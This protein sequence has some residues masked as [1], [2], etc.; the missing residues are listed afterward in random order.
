MTSTENIIAVTLAERP[1]LLD[2][3]NTLIG[4]CWPEFMK[5]D[6]VSNRLWSRLYADFLDFQYVL[7]DAGG[8]LLAGCNS[9]PVWWDGDDTGLPD[10]G[11]DWALESGVDN[12]LARRVPNTLS[13][14]G[15]QVDPAQ[16]DR[17]VSSAA[18][19][20]MRANA[21]PRGIRAL[22]APVRPPMKY[23]YPLTSI[24]RYV[25][26]TNA[27]G[28]LFDPWLRVHARMGAR[29]IRPCHQSMRIAGSVAEWAQGTGMAFPESGRYVVPTALEPVE[30]DC[31]ADRGLYVEPNVWMVHPVDG[32]P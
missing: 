32:V 5:H 6:A 10:L 14:I 11:W 2:A 13:A 27:D 17:G 1:D 3:A 26:W 7:L 9:I 4:S 21:P 28:E 23:V 29:L 16:R 15:I 12:F 19:Q 25:T 22:I 31:E 20:A 8:A 30:I 24:D 18:L